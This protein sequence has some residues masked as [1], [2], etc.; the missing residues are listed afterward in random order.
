MKATKLC[1]TVNRKSLCG[2]LKKI[3]VK[4]GKHEVSK[5]R[6]YL[7]KELNKKRISIE[8]TMELQ[9]LINTC[10]WWAKNV[11]IHIDVE[12]IKA[13]KHE[14]ECRKEKKLLDY[15]I[16]QVQEGKMTLLDIKNEGYREMVLEATVPGRDTQ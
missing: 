8:R 1:D 6:D 15:F 14:S 11:M 10:D 3:Y 2:Y 5:Y 7:S 9:E 4:G 13:R 16:N 12:T